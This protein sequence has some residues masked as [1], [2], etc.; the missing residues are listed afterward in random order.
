MKNKLKSILEE[1]EKAK[2]INENLSNMKDAGWWKLR[3]KKKEAEKQ[4]GG[5]IGNAIEFEDTYELF[6]K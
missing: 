2:L 1:G 4:S 3:S 6:L 5:F